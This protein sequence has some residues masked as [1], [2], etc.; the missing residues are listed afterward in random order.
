M[1]FVRA[2]SAVT[3]MA[4]E[5]GTTVLDI[6][7]VEVCVMAVAHGVAAAESR[8]DRKII[9]SEYQMLWWLLGLRGRES[10]W[11]ATLPTAEQEGRVFLLNSCLSLHV[12]IT[13]IK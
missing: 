6:E 9:G 3:G 2:S 12:L 4:M 7:A 1:A 13:E 5:G 11:P 8:F 10:G